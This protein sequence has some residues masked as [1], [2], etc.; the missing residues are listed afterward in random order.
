[1]GCQGV[2][3]NAV[4]RDR[5]VLRGVL[6]TRKV[7]GAS[8]FSSEEK[9]KNDKKQE[10][11]FYRIDDY[12]VGNRLYLDAEINKDNLSKRFKIS[13]SQLSMLIN[14]HCG[15]NFSDYINKQRVNQAKELLKDDSFSGYT[16]VAIGLECGF[17]SKSTFYSAFKKI[18]GVIPVQF[19]KRISYFY[20]VITLAV[21]INYKSCFHFS[22][23]YS[24]QTENFNFRSVCYIDFTCYNK[25]L[26]ICGFKPLKRDVTCRCYK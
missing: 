25:V 23:R 18:T 1:M 26:F 4:L 13:T 7:A 21:T 10:S 15:C 12:I 9:L 16:I 8:E 2:F 17:N 22:M 19:K 6:K 14:G 11:A 24:K 5:I 3:R 20:W